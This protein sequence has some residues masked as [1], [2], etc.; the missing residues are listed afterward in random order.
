[1]AYV[2]VVVVVQDYLTDI[3]KFGKLFQ[4]FT[5]FANIWLKFL[6]N[7]IADFSNRFFC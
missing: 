1:M 2:V 7:L 6:E 5:K 3:L 4:V